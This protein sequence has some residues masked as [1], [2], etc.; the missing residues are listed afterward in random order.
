MFESAC[1]RDGILF[2]RILLEGFKVRFGEE[3]RAG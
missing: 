1:S 2:E 3:G